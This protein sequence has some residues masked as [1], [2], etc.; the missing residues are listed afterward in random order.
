MCSARCLWA[1]SWLT[2]HDLPIYLR[3]IQP[4]AC[5]LNYSTLKRLQGQ[6]NPPLNELGQAQAEAL[7]DRLQAESAALIFSSDLQRAAQTAETIAHGYTQQGLPLGG[8][9]TTVTCL[10]A[11]RERS[12]GVLE[13]SPPSSPDHVDTMRDLSPDI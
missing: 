4:Y 12:L 8:Q 2:N 1:Q 10:P 5:H 9:Q 7:A 13:V 11:F 3:E 6:K